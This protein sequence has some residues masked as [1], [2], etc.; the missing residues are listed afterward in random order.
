MNDAS[1]HHV[2]DNIEVAESTPPKTVH[3][4]ARRLLFYRALSLTLNRRSF[5]MVSMIA[6]ALR[7]LFLSIMA[8]A[9]PSTDAPTFVT[10][11]PTQLSTPIM[12][13]PAL[14]PTLAPT[15]TRSS[16]GS[17][18]VLSFMRNA[19]SNT[20]EQFI[21][22]SITGETAGTG[23]VRSPRLPDSIH[24]VVTP[25][26]FTN[27]PLPARI[28]TFTLDGIEQTGIRVEAT[29]EIAV[30]GSTQREFS[31][32]AFLGL[33][34]KLLGTEY[35]VL[36]Y[37]SEF[38]NQ[39]MVSGFTVVA[40]SDD[41]VIT[42]TLSIVPLPDKR[43]VPYNVSLQAL[44]AYQLLSDSPER[45]YTGTLITSNKPV[46]VFSGGTCALVPLSLRACDHLISQLPPPDTWGTTFLAVPLAAFTRGDTYRI[47]ARERNTDVIIDGVV[48]ATLKARSYFETELSSFTV[49]EIVTTKP[50]LVAQYARFFSAEFALGDPFQMLLLSNE[51]F[52][53][54][55][56]LSAP[57]PSRQNRGLAF[58]INVVVRITDFRNCRINGVSFTFFSLSFGFEPIGTSGFAGGQ[59]LVERSVY[60]LTCPSPFGAYFYALGNMVGYGYPGGMTLPIGG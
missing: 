34:T 54:S 53:D 25:G 40:D 28:V 47:L 27:V 1:S 6:L 37:R 9:Q 50:C 30:Y 4:S 59:L 46:A 48:V 52:L 42:I 41:T 31:R 21:V 57:R 45:D 51:Q 60:H 12:T 18:F 43:G 38:L 15:H 11:T 16:L 44:D 55:Y 20:T 58:F 8:G 29:N 14:S 35:I 26:G 49:H 2:A 22:L 24:F 19:R 39:L 33:P 36:G 17:S 10:M 7:T 32:G 56:T 3:T 13:A 5:P 23:F